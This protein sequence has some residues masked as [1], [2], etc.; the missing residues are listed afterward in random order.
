MSEMVAE[1]KIL[2]VNMVC[3]KCK[4]GIMECY[5][6]VV[7]TTYPESYPHKCKNCGNVENYNQTYP[8]QKLV[9]VEPLRKPTKEEY[10]ED[11]NEHDE[12]N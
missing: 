3:N 7:L 11:N 8:F 10:E 1:A 6:N 12:Y 9:P 4:K 2:I 5:G